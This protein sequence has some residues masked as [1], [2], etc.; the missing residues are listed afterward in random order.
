MSSMPSNS[1]N[2]NIFDNMPEVVTQFKIES[3]PQLVIQ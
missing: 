2:Y 1:K 3:Q